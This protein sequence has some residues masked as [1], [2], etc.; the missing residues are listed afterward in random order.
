MD[1][2]GADAVRRVSRRSTAWWRTATPHGRTRAAAVRDLVATIARLTRD[3]EGAGPATPPPAPRREDVLADQLAVVT[4]DLL[5][6]L[7][8]RPDEETARAAAKAYDD[9]TNEVDPR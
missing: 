4:Y 8:A 7:D 6:A 2:A 5:A 3:V 9:V 1:K